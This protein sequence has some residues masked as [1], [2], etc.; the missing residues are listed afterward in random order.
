M[1]D[2]ADA[3]RP[4]PER[5]EPLPEPV[6]QRVVGL[7]SDGLGALTPDEVP[8]SLRAFARFTPSRR[9]KLAATPIAAALESDPS[10][11]QRVA[12]RVR[13]G[14]PDLAAA[15]DA[16]TVPAAADPLD[17][18]AV[19]YLLRPT[20][21][22]ALVE[23]AGREVERATI[24]NRSAEAAD[25]VARLRGEL[26]AAR[27][28]ARVEADRLRAERDAARREAE[29]LRRQVRQARDGFR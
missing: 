1:S 29:D 6:R 21:W 8:S 5:P 20:G 28:A 10:F 27:T 23:T 17:V 16:G 24:Q 25:A 7:A 18:A 14:V 12:E 26:A 9:A 2:I 19:A 15:L 4:G 11:R 3:G 22:T 13:Q